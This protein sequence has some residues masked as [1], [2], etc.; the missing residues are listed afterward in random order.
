MNTDKIIAD[1]KEADQ[2]LIG[3]KAHHDAIK[4]AIECIESLD[5]QLIETLETQE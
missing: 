2:H 5:N 1:L 3:G 4:A